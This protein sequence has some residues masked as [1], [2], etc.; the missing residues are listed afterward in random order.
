MLALILD[1]QSLHLARILCS[2]DPQ[3][4]KY[5]DNNPDNFLLA[6]VSSDGVDLELLTGSHISSVVDIPLENERLIQQCYFRVK[7]KLVTVSL[8]K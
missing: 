2:S 8:M 5:F 1:P 6:P 4:L 3:S 7:T